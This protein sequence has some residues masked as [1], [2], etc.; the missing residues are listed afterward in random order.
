MIYCL[1][2]Q[3]DFLIVLF[4]VLVVPVVPAAAQTF[5]G[6][7][8][9]FVTS[10]TPVIG[11]NGVVGGISVDANGIVARVEIDPSGQLD[12]IQ[13]QPKNRV[14][15]K[16]Q[17]PSHLRKISLR[18]LEQEIDR[19]R[20]A[21][22]PL[23][24]EMVLLAGLQRI[25]YVFVDPE[26]NDIILA[27]PA[28]GWRVGK[29]GF[30]VGNARGLPVIDLCDLVTMLRTRQRDT[31]DG[32]T[33]SMD[34]TPEGKKRYANYMRKAKPQ[35]NEQTLRQ[36]KAAIGDYEVT[37]TGIAARSH[38][39][40]ILIASDLMMK[41]LGMNLEPSPVRGVKS[42]VQ[43]LQQTAKRVPQDQ[44]PRWWLTSD[45]EP[46]LR[47]EA[48]LAW[49]IR[50][51]AVK[52]MTIDDYFDRNGKK[53]GS[54]NTNR[55]A[56]RWAN[57]FTKHYQELSVELPIFGQLRNCM[58]LAVVAALL[59]KYE[60]FKKAGFHPSSLVDADQVQLAEFPVPQF[61]RPQISYAP[62]RR[63]WVVTL[64]GGIGIDG[65]SIASNTEIDADLPAIHRQ[66]VESSGQSWWWD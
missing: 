23:T 32:I 55:L 64:S 36:M 10:I 34:A 6:G 56:G 4:A 62:S 24:D 66:A 38:F 48:G 15:N 45:Y 63:G 27:G 61:T 59:N 3:P 17:R 5:S 54:R 22:L 41:R 42:Y 49:K 1:K 58:D 44:S 16:A 9:P 26:H 25:E 46:L 8:R 47:D 28:D 2:K 14:S 29:T 37:F 21:K 13:S 19:L 39:A 33:C 43:M 50:G 53:V 35:F 65:W 51:Q 40:R 18:K 7:F 11:P 31:V 60:L 57:N 20:E 12:Q 52:A 30:I